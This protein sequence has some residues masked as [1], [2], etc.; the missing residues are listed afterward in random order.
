MAMMA[1][2]VIAS[3]TWLQQVLSRPKLLHFRCVMTKSDW[4]AL[5]LTD[6]QVCYL[7]SVLVSSL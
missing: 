2:A 1:A 3:G 7:Q 6:Q 5:R 4:L